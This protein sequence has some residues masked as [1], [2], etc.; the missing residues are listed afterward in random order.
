MIKTLFSQNGGKSSGTKSKG[1]GKNRY[2]KDLIFIA[3]VF[4]LVRQCYVFDF[5]WESLRLLCSTV[6]RIKKYFFQF[7]Y[8]SL[9]IYFVSFFN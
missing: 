3:V 7:V 2:K 8:Y 9:Q 1:N 5:S 4:L 6:C